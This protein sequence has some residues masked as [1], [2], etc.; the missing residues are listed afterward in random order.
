MS[1]DWRERLAG[2]ID[3]YRAGSPDLSQQI[4]TLSAE[5]EAAVAVAE[6][7]DGYLNAPWGSVE[8]DDGL[9]KMDDTLAAYRRLKER[10]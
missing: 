3:S 4:D 7:A 8:R 9:G 1:K 5:I 6:A 10:A 2:L